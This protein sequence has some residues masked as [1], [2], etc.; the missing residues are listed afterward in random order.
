MTDPDKTHHRPMSVRLRD[1]LRRHS[2]PGGGQAEAT[3]PQQCLHTEP[4]ARQGGGQERA[5]TLVTP[6]V[7]IHRLRGLGED[8]PGQLVP[9]LAAGHQ[10][11][12]LPRPVHLVHLGAGVGQQGR[13][14]LRSPAHHRLTQQNTTSREI[15]SLEKTD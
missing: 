4:E 11:R 7:D 8:D 13:N 10:Q 1:L 2:L 15:T 6:L 14:T 9:A 3:A 5:E 12:S